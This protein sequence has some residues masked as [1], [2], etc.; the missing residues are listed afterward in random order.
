MLVRV[1][2]TLLVLSVKIIVYC[3]SSYISYTFTQQEGLTSYNIKSIAQDKYGFIWFGT[4]DGLYFFNGKEFKQL[5]DP[6][7]ANSTRDVRQVLYDSLFNWIW[8][9]YTSGGL[10]AYDCQRHILKQNV[11]PE[12]TNLP[13]RD[14]QYLHFTPSHKLMVAFDDKLAYTRPVQSDSSS[15]IR[16][17]Q[18]IPTGR[19]LYIGNLADKQII[20]LA[21]KGV[22]PLDLKQ[23]KVGKAIY[24]YP[25]QSQVIYTEG[26]E[27]FHATG[28]TVTKFD[29]AHQTS[30]TLQT[31]NPVTCINRWKDDR[32]LLSTTKG[33]FL[34]NFATGENNPIDFYAL[35]RVNKRDYVL[36]S[37]WDAKGNLWIGNSQSLE[38]SFLEKPFLFNLSRSATGLPQLGH[39][40]QLL[41]WDNKKLLIGDLAGCYL[42]D[43][44]SLKIV[45]TTSGTFL[46]EKIDSFKSL[47]SG[48]GGVK[49]IDPHFRSSPI[50]QYFPEWREYQRSHFLSSVYLT[51]QISVLSTDEGFL[52]LWNRNEKKCTPIQAGHSNGWSDDN[53]F[54]LFRQNNHT[55]IAG[56][57][58][59]ITV[60]DIT[61]GVKTIHEFSHPLT[62]E[63]ITYFFDI[64]KVGDQ[65][66]IGTYGYGILVTDEQFTIK[67]IINTKSGL[68]NNGVYKL[69]NDD[70]GDIWAS[71]NNGLNRIRIQ[72]KRVKNFYIEDGI[73]NNVFEQYCGSQADGKLYFGG[74]DGFTTVC[75]I[76]AENNQQRP[77]LN[78]YRA[79]YIRDK[80]ITSSI[81]LGTDQII[82]KNDVL[83]S[84]LYFT[85]NN[86]IAS[87]KNRFAYRITGV[88]ETWL[89][90][91]NDNRISII[92]LGPGHYELYVRTNNESNGLGDEK[93][94]FLSIEPKWYQTK[95]FTLALAL[96]SLLIVYTIYR[97]RLKQI[98]EQ[99]AIRKRIAS[100]LHDDFGSTLNSIKIFVNLAQTSGDRQGTMEMIKT[101]LSQASFSLREMIWVLDDARDTLEDFIARLRQFAGPILEASHI[102]LT[103]DAKGEDLSY[104]LKKEVKRNLFLICKEAINNSLKYSGASSI[105]L[106]IRTIRKGVSIEIRDN[107]LG[108]EQN[109]SKKGNGLS[110]MVYRCKEIGYKFQLVSAPNQGTQISIHP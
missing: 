104:K 105:M 33:N 68:S 90:L 13:V 21:G 12:K 15:A 1:I 86:I 16:L 75:P 79:Q 109:S 37:L 60:Y 72:N 78:F 14:I 53:F 83:Q 34:G 26:P 70:L 24:S 47:Y 100:D 4:Q 94:F 44:N 3:Q 56:Q 18:P 63:R 22:Y 55:L 64:L 87:K 93:K 42:L 19:V 91:D 7:S 43:D 82:V 73:H 10:Q 23:G 35:G 77:A 67:G 49:I 29:I 81:N 101:S 76:D 5:T 25:A 40:Y 103:I 80:T 110:N 52:L 48:V 62:G 50:A 102:E 38:A 32:M 20:T 51:N 88:N 92:G 85:S 45:D 108:F 71:T 74:V 31:A 2:I 69:L 11:L 58:N 65:Y 66:W 107:G 57:K 28:L 54:C 84:N 98:Q 9:A 39:L 46:L 61:T 8:V 59:G 106:N 30:S 27:Y 89:P 97:L 17:Q 41:P 36:T 95:V 96:L 6:A 99:H